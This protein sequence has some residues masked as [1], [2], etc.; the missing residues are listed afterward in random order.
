[1]YA[2]KVKFFQCKIDCHIYII[3]YVN[4]LVPTK[5]KPTIDLQITKRSESEHTAIKKKNTLICKGR[6]QK[7]R[8]KGT[9]D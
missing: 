7:K 1:M 5:Q 9:T 2:I 4:F 6:Q 3:F 8:K